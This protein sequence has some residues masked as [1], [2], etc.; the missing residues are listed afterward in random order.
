MIQQEIETNLLADYEE[1][2]SKNNL[3]LMR[4]NVFA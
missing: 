2:F 4:E 1:L 3:S